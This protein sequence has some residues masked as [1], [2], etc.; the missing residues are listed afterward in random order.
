MQAVKE[1]RND[2]YESGFPKKM[3]RT[4]FDLVLNERLRA[5]RERNNLNMPTVIKALNAKGVSIGVST[6]WGY[7]A[8]ETNVNHRYPS[9]GMLMELAEFYGCST[10]YLFGLSDKFRPSAVGTRQTDIRDLLD[11]KSALSYND[12]R[13]TPKQR[14]DI[15]KKLDSYIKKIAQ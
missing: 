15:M 3:H 13:L 8:D 14:Q 12:V 7:E 11:S 4:K 5:A 6:L 9:I 2:T 1:D 10:D